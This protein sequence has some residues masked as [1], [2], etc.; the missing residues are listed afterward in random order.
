M[1]GQRKE[2]VIGERKVCD[3]KQKGESDRREEGV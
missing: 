2:R 3:M 1:T